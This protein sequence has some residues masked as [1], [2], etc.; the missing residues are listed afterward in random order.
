MATF[1][2]FCSQEK[3]LGGWGFV[4]N[5]SLGFG[6]EN[7]GRDGSIY[8]CLAKE[9]VDRIFIIPLGVQDLLL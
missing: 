3:V 8:E 2:R 9:D 4:C 5:W 7:G 6:T 1:V